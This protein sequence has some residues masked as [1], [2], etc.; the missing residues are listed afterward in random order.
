LDPITVDPAV[1]LLELLLLQLQLLHCRRILLKSDQSKQWQKKASQAF[2][3]AQQLLNEKLFKE[4]MLVAVVVVD[5][6]RPSKKAT[7]PTLR[8]A[9][10][11]GLSSTEGTSTQGSEKVKVHAENPPNP[12]A[13][14]NKRDSKKVKFGVFW[15]SFSCGSVVVR[16]LDDALRHK[17]SSRGDFFGI[18][19]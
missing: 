9:S 1:G 8:A 7:T 2:H 14:S 16:S 3:Y 6:S 15:W 12:V 10:V 19:L 4:P 18:S 5:T 13:G 17:F 11:D